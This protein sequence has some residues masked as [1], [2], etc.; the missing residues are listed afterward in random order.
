MD[1]NGYF[2]LKLQGLLHEDLHYIFPRPKMKK[3]KQNVQILYLNL[4]GNIYIVVWFEA[5]KTD[6]FF[7]ILVDIWLRFDIVGFLSSCDI[8]ISLL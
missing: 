8:Q 1:N 2:V 4:M 7:L 5:V 3:C 6:F